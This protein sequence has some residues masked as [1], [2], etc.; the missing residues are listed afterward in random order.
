M[1]KRLITIP[2]VAPVVA[3]ALVALAPPANTLPPRRRLRR[4]G[5]AH[6]SLELQRRQGALW[7][8]LQ[9]GQ[10]ESTPANHPR[11]Q[12]GSKGRRTGPIMGDPVAGRHAVAQAANACDGG[13]R[14]QD[15]EDR[16]GAD[17]ARRVL[18]SFDR[19]AEAHHLAARSQPPDVEPPR[20]QA[21]FR[22]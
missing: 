22:Y 12:L 17:G 10:A 6:A 16:L 13:A 5:R 14:E 3:T 20:C 2:G 21:K 11:R 8:H 9:D 1:A 7:A 15:R 4:L 19:R 18:Q